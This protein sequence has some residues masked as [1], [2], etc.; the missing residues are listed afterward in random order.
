VSDEA[1]Y[2]TRTALPFDADVTA[3]YELPHLT[4]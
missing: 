3:P 1:R 2:V 4:G